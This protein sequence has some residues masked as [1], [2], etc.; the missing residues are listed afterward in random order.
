M[1]ATYLLNWGSSRMYKIT[2]VTLKYIT[3]TILEDYYDFISSQ[4]SE[5]TSSVSLSYLGL[6]PI[7]MSASYPKPIKIK[8]Y[9]S[10]KRIL[11]KQLSTQKGQTYSKLTPGVYKITCKSGHVYIGETKRSLRT[12]CQRTKQ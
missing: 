12:R 1:R 8:V 11:F 7:N 4:D 5:P 3:I 2:M 10:S 6:F 9:H